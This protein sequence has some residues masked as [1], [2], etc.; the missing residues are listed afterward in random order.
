MI[1]QVD[2]KIKRSLVRA[3]NGPQAPAH[4]HGNDKE[5]GGPE[6]SNAQQEQTIE[7]IEQ[8]EQKI[9]VYNENAEKLGE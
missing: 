8:I 5:G 1:A 2:H 6:M 7:K 3:E 4:N 9:N